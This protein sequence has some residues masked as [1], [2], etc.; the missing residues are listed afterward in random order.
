MDTKEI[1][2][3]VSGVLK[4][5]TKSNGNRQNKNIWL[6]FFVQ[7]VIA[8]VIIVGGYYTLRGDVDDNYKEIKDN[9]THIEAEVKRATDIDNKREEDLTDIKLKVNTV[10]IQ[11]KTVMT[12]QEDIADDIDD[13]DEKIDEVLRRLPRK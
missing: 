7:L 2:D 10:E 5:H 12:R 6:R 8:I 4:E 9:R 1:A 3:V 11:Q 13:V